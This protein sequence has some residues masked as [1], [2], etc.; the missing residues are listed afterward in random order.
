MAGVP[1]VAKKNQFGSANGVKVGVR[2]GS[3]VTMCS[4]FI[5]VWSASATIILF[6][7]APVYGFSQLSWL[8]SRSRLRTIGS[9]W[10][11]IG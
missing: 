7:T 8:I 5:P 9:S 3:A 4:V 6:S 11:R 10:S 1:L 2:K